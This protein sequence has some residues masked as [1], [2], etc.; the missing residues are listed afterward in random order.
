[1]TANIPKCNRSRIVAMATITVSLLLPVVISVAAVFAALYFG[2]IYGIGLIA[3][4]FNEVVKTPTA[5]NVIALLFAGI[6]TAAIVSIGSCYAGKIAQAV[7][8]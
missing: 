7:S 6:T 1:M 8:A 5:S 2:A 3:P 4:Y